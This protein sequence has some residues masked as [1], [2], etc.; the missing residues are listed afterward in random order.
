MTRDEVSLEALE[1]TRA[2]L[3]ET[4]PRSLTQEERDFLINLKTGDPD[5]SLLPFPSLQ[6]M[7][8]F[9]RRWRRR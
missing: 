2:W 7:P 4:L 5:W 9:W 3:F 8:R 6:N 1:D